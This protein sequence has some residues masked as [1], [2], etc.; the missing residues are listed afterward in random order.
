MHHRFASIQNPTFDSAATFCRGTDSVAR[1]AAV[2][3]ISRFTTKS[4]VAASPKASHKVTSPERSI[5]LSDEDSS[6]VAAEI[7]S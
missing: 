5:S 2:C 1:C 6:A 7:L 4:F 3:R